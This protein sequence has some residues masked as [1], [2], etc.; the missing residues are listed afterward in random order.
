MEGEIEHLSMFGLA[1]IP[2]LM[3][4]GRLI[5]DISNASV[6]GRHR[7]P[8]PQW[9]WPNDSEP[10]IFSRL[11]APTGVENV[12]IKPSITAEIADDR[13][14]QA[15]GCD[16]ISIWEIRSSRFGTS[17]LRNQSDLTGFR[18]LAAQGA[19]GLRCP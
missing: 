13:I 4:L 18:L 14:V 7:E 16:E 11:V 9:A 5:S 2:I 10:L 15:M 17:A 19:P 3:E 12:A 6:F 8:K 1:P